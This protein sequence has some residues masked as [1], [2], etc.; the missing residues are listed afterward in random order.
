MTILER[1]LAKVKRCKNGCWEWTGKRALGK[2]PYGYFRIGSKGHGAH[3]AA[4]LLLRGE[5]PQGLQVCHHC[6]NCGCVNPDHLFLGTQKDNIQDATRKGRMPSGDNTWARL[7]PELRYRCGAH[8]KANGTHT[9]PERVARGERVGGAK[10]MA[11]DVAEIRRLHAEGNLGYILL[12][13]R[14]GVTSG[15]VRNIVKGKIWRHVK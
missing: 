12:G 9:H 8:G 10:L 4:W 15:N 13:R 7:H 3:R 1:F 5:I 6:D 11:V 2:W 14:F